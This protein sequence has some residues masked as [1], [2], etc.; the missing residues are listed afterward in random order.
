MCWL[1]WIH[2]FR[3]SCVVCLEGTTWL[4]CVHRP[5]GDGLPR[6][7]AMHVWLLLF[8]FTYQHLDSA[9]CWSP[10][11]FLSNFDTL[12]VPHCRNQQGLLLIQSR[13]PDIVWLFFSWKWSML[14]CRLQVSTQ[15]SDNSTLTASQDSILLKTCVCDVILRVVSVKCERMWWKES[16]QKNVLGQF[17]P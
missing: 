5:E 10:N 4:H 14:H 7:L 2:C 12:D 16:V 9:G 1:L 11:R 15:E 8:L 17:D 6:F 3:V 13:L